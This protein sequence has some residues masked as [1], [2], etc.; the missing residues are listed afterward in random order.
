MGN[1]NCLSKDRGD[2]AEYLGEDFQKFSNDEPEFIDQDRPLL[3]GA[4]KPIP[5]IEEISKIKEKIHE[6]IIESSKET[7]ITIEEITEDDFISE[8]NK[9]QNISRILKNNEDE[10]NTFNYE[11]DEKIYN[12]PPLKFS[13]KK[14]N[15][16]EFYKGTY[17]EYGN[18]CGKGIIITK[19]NNVY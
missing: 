10:I 12:V 17:D 18:I 15:E 9:N 13:N 6:K 3:R 11:G 5:S 8:L 19:E 4:P 2:E 7:E 16:N 1:C 14:T